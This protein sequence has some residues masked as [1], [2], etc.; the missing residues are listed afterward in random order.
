[1]S[2]V[3]RFGDWGR[4]NE[5]R[6]ALGTLLLLFVFVW[7]WPSIVISI[8][9][10]ERGVL[11]SR[12]TGTHTGRVYPEGL[13]LIFPWDE[14]AIYTTRYQTAERSFVVL[15]KDGLPISVDLTI[16]YKPSDKQVARLHQSVGPNYV[17]TVVVPE[18][19]N[20]LRGVIGGFRPE[21]LYAQS[22][23]TIQ[24]EVVALARVQTGSRYVLLD[25]VLIKKLTLPDSVTAAIQSKLTQEQLALEM[26][27]RIQRET[28][29]ARRKAIEAGGIREFQRVISETMTDR[30][31]QY[32]GVEAT[33]ELA[34]SN[35]AKVIVIGSGRG[36][37]PL[38]LNPDGST[39][40]RSPQE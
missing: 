39:V 6:V 2:I 24:A 9:A 14:M 18:V 11:W 12:F 15:S 7:Y 5:I 31:L 16:R 22:F 1:M 21:E 26:A 35:N 20:S 23:E 34:K 38:I 28:E 32:K 10:G 36:N 27:Y 30:T 8:R 33:L 13:H 40:I 25:D 29:E 4:R 37:L 17:E 3:Q 19:A